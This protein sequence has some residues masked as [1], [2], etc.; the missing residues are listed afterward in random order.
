MAEAAEGR[1]SAGS[2]ESVVGFATLCVAFVLVYIG[3]G[4]FVH[5]DEGLLG[6]AVATLIAIAATA[7]RVAAYLWRPPTR[8]LAAQS[9][10]ALQQR[11]RARHHVAHFFRQ[12]VIDFFAQ[13]FIFRRG[14]WRWAQHWLI[15]WGV[16]GSFAI[17]IPLT[18]GWFH[19]ETLS[20]GTYT[21]VLGTIPL[22]QFSLGTIV[23]DL[24][25]NALNL[26]A[27]ALLVGLLMALARRYFL[28]DA[29]VD[30]RVSYDLFPLFLL[31]A[32]TLTGLGL[33]VSYLFFGGRFH[34]EIGLAHEAAV[35]LLLLVF[36]FSKL[37]HVFVRPLAQL[38]DVYHRAND[39][40]GLKRC[41]RC[42]RVYASERQI[43]DVKAVLAEQGWRFPVASPNGHAVVHTADLCYD[44]KRIHHGLVW[45][46][47]GVDFV[48]LAPRK[49]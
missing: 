38:V 17:T 33:T 10:A 3:S 39:A 15:A 43:A 4:R 5:F 23:G 13:R 36:P 2:V 46:G 49:E 28:Y 6:Y 8:R 16:I 29:A 32:V 25:F 1:A 34:A 44:C 30:Q 9:L 26:A 24:I 35:V 27:L 48:P 42:R 22:F 7:A 20:E 45:S 41:A 21:A 14:A 40:A 18:F 11:P 37:F 31:L 19:F 12:L 47:R